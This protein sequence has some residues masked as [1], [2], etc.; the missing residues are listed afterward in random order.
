VFPVNGAQWSD[1]DGD[2]FGDNSDGEGGD[3]CLLVI[4]TSNQDRNGCVDTDGDGWS[5]PDGAWTVAEGAD[6]FPDEFTQHS[7]QDGDG[8]GDASDGV[9]SDA[10][11]LNAGTSTEDRLGCIDSDGDGWSDANDALPDDATQHSDQDGDGFGDSETGTTPD[12]CPEIFGTSDMER[13]GCPDPDGDGWAGFLDA[14][15]D[16]ERF[17]SDA[18][19]DGYPDQEGTNLS[20]DCPEV[21]G[22]STEDRVG[23]V[24]GDG[25]G[26]SDDGDSYPKD[27]S[28]FA[29]ADGSSSSN[30]LYLIVGFLC[31]MA[32]LVLGYAVQRRN[33]EESAIKL[34]PNLPQPMMMTPVA[35]L[36]A[37]VVQAAAPAGPPLPAE[38]LPA[39]WTLDQWAWYG[40]DYLRNQ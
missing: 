12:S 4:G 1:G 11:P 22:T 14:F 2:G 32:V 35:P 30:T 28:R 6:A 36:V 20:D 7:D 17:W 19:G 29:S 34:Q 9:Q 5:N 27:A 26:W 25:D 16:D 24:D 8:Y 39:G 23:C 10:C 40:E 21:P 15:P 3:Q 31:V 38:G 18:D 13:Y 33:R 37:P